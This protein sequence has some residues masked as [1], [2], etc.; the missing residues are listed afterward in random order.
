MKIKRDHR[1]KCAA[2]I[3]QCWLLFRGSIYDGIFLPFLS[4]IVLSR[5]LV[6]GNKQWIQLQKSKKSNGDQKCWRGQGCSVST[7]L[8]SGPQVYSEEENHD[9]A[10]KRGDP[11]AVLLATMKDK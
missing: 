1:I 6:K 5:P 8:D 2:H 11:Y 7:I 9:P 10:S 4:T 3:A